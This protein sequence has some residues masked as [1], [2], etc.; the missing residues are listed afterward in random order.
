MRVKRSSEFLK[1]FKNGRSLRENGVQIYFR[2]NQPHDKS[3]LGIV[4]SRKT[5]SRAV[6]RNRARRMV[7]EY[8]RENH[9][10]FREKYDLIIRIIEGAKVLLENN[11]H[12]ILERA[13]ERAGLFT[14]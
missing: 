8:F 5:F 11:L 13:I 6:D 12:Q 14:K 9:G 1:V 3:R 10:R 2:A 4:V 7:R